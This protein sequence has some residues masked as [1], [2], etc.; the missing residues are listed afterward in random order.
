MDQLEDERQFDTTELERSVTVPESNRKIVEEI[1]KYALTST[2]SA[3]AAS[4]R[5]SSSPP[6]TCRTRRHADQLVD[7]A[8]DVFGRGDAFVEKITGGV[9]RPLQRIREFRNRPSPASRSPWTCSRTGVDIPDLEFIVFLRPVKS[10]ILFEQM[11][12]RGTRK[13]E[14]YPDKDHFTVFDC[15]DGTL[16]ALL[17]GRHG[18]HRRRSRRRRRGR[19]RRSSRTS[20]TTATATTTSAAW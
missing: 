13:G 4:R 12:G 11:L 1:K 16:L 17:Q 19:S 8:R 2:R 15:F 14:K 20:G 10:R 5:R 9:D 6:T 7:L 18:D 3:M